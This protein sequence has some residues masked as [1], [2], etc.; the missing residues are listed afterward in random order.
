MSETI[1]FEGDEVR[2][3]QLLT[4]RRACEIEAFMGLGHSRGSVIAVVK[5]NHGYK[6]NKIKVFEQ[7]QR[8][9]TEQTGVPYR[10]AVR[11]AIEHFG[12]A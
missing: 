4:Q 1:V 3:V 2:K 9:V 5:R 11:K 7:F 10:P 6:G 8:Y 12:R